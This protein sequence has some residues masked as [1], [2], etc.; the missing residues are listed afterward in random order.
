[1]NNIIRDDSNTET[2]IATEW[3][4]LREAAPKSTPKWIA[5]FQK[6]MRI[7]KQ[8]RSNRAKFIASEKQKMQREIESENEMML[9]DYTRRKALLDGEEHLIKVAIA[10]GSSL[11]GYGGRIDLSG[12][13]ADREINQLLYASRINSESQVKNTLDVKDIYDRSNEETDLLS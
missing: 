1:M 4:A 8:R 11:S 13:R 6:E 5:N 9:Y 12:K 2:V 3:D 7:A 10:N